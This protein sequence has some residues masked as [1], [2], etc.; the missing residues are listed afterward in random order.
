MASF[1]RRINS[2]RPLLQRRNFSSQSS[3]LT[4]D[5]STTGRKKS[6]AVLSLL[7][8]EANP[9]IILH[10][11]RTA[12]LSPENTLDRVA[13]SVAISKL[14]QSDCFDGIRLLVEELK[15]RP[16]WRNERFV[17]HSIILYGQAGL[18]K[19][20]IATFEEMGELGIHRTVKSLNALLFACILAKKFDEVKRIF[21]DFPK[22]YNIQPDTETYNHV[23][24]AYCELDKSCLGFSVLSEMVSKRCKPNETTFG[25]LIAGF[26]KEGKHDDVGKVL[27][28]MEEYGMKPGPSTYNF[29]IKSLCKLGRSYEAKALLDGM[30]ARG[31]NPNSTIY[32]SLIHGFC[33]EGKFEDAKNLFNTMVKH[34]CEPDADC[35]YTLISFLCQG[36]DYVSALHFSKQSMEKDWVPYFTTMK[37]LVEGLASISKVEEAKQLVAQIKGRYPKAAHIWKETEEALS[38]NSAICKKTYA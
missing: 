10:I 37:S 19:N 22:M 27:K 21:T 11:C 30:L 28:L 38:N 31:L 32:L 35:Y 4:P 26:Y 29:R 15:I 2:F 25:H 33:K 14:A 1:I 13:M 9:E 34:G 5:F 36:R 12:T 3:I 8:S 6:R 16:D 24:E 7:K 20:A 17:S 18:L 23:I